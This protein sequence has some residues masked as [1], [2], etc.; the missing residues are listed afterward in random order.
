MTIQDITGGQ[1]VLTAA[2]LCF[3][4]QG[5][6][7]AKRL[8]DVECRR[9]GRDFSSAKDAAEELFHQKDVLIFISAAGIAVR[10]VAEL[11]SDKT[12]DPA[13]IVIDDCGRFVIPVLSGHLGMANTVAETLAQRL[14][15]QA[16][17]TTASDARPGVEAVDSLAMREGL[18]ITDRNAAKIITAAAV[19]GEY[20]RR[21]DY[22]GGVIVLTTHAGA[23]AML[24]L[25]PKRYV[26]G[27]G[28]RKGIDSDALA[29]FVQQ[30]MD[31]LDI[32]SEDVFRIASIDRKASEPAILSLSRN[33]HVPFSV[34]HAAQLNRLGGLFSSSVFVRR[35]VGTDN[36]CER[37]ALAACGPGG[38]RIV[39]KK[40]IKEGMTLAIAE[41]NFTGE[42]AGPKI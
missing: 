4:R 18:T 23:G 19:N 7:L 21:V 5:E 40:Q 2:L 16:V 17:I 28:C 10:A 1:R 42:A 36:V 29:S 11:L 6:A 39:L 22:D 34:F 41:R 15:A 9:H 13:V 33:L 24:T 25:F 20:V 26:L 31:Q 38:G 30:T 27:V 3:T 35:T 12:T 8:P 32:R 37:S 14:G